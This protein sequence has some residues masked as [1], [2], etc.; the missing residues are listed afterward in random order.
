MTE[1]S[2]LDGRVILPV[3]IY[4][5]CEPDSYEV[6]YIGKTIESPSRRL[7]FHIQ[8]AKRVG[9]RPVCFWL[10]K[11]M[12][13][14]IRPSVIN[15]EVVAPG[16]DWAEREKY[17]IDFYRANSGKGRILNLTDG[18]E[19]T[20]GH[21]YAGTEHAKRIG[22]AHRRGSYFAC[23][24]CSSEF[25]R[26]PHEIRNGDCRF[27]SRYCYHTAQRGISK[28]IPE[29]MKIKSIAALKIVAAIK[30]A[31]PNCKHGHPFTKENTKLNRY[32]ARICKICERASIDKYQLR[33]RN[34]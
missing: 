24:R 19:G 21:L 9:K 32:G 16:H 2:F 33:I 12:A 1:Q 6:R 11:R 29:A 22:N 14:G 30:R 13:A 20:S 18:G 8:Q 27:C 25:F 28:P 10:R 26:K 7:T 31:R 4:A 3:N 17:W 34:G 15:L 23:E 5:L